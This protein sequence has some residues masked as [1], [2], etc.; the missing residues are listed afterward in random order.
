MPDHQL[1]RDFRPAPDHG[2]NLP[3]DTEV[4]S[5]KFGRIR[6]DIWRD[7]APATVFRGDPPR[8]V[9]SWPDRNWRYVVQGVMSGVA[10]TEEG[11]KSKG[12]L[13]AWK[14]QSNAPTVIDGEALV[15]APGLLRHQLSVGEMAIDEGVLATQRDLIT[16][17]FPAEGAKE[18]DLQ[19]F[20]L[21]KHAPLSAKVERVITFGH[22][23]AL[24]LLSRTAD[25][26]VTREMI[27]CALPETDGRGW[28]YVATEP[29]AAIMDAW[30]K[31]TL[32][33]RALQLDPQTVHYVIRDAKRMC[34]AGSEVPLIR[35]KGMVPEAW[36]PDAGVYAKMFEKDNPDAS[37]DPF[38]P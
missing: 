17:R 3:P 8:V 25:D 6:V 23:P 26:G 21:P 34:Q 16:A 22:D 14:N 29:T 38:E 36:L 12:E 27:A 32:D 5:A 11:A 35:V 10:A 37:D 7:P 30:K 2:Y 19:E 13:T 28:A 33:L 9:G 4:Q 31:E 20:V 1:I 24:A 15:F 18:Q